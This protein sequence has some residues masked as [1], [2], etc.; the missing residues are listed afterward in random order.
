MV[1]ELP[2][3]DARTVK[4]RVVSQHPDDEKARELLYA[5]DTLNDWIVE[6]QKKLTGRVDL[7]GLGRAMMLAGV[8]DEMIAQ[9]LVD[10]AKDAALLAETDPVN[11]IKTARELAKANI[12]RDQM[13]AEVLDKVLDVA[14]SERESVKTDVLRSTG[15]GD[16]LMNLVLNAAWGMI[17]STPLPQ[18]SKPATSAS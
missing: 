16:S 7:V 11:A 12:E 10:A 14:P 1:R 18:D 4:V 5:L 9:R 15:A 13:R 3:S 6:R 8:P 2:L 17:P